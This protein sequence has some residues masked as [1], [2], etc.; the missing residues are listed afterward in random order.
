MRCQQT[1]SFHRAAA[2]EMFICLLLRHMPGPDPASGPGISGA[3]L[4]RMVLL[5]S[6]FDKGRTPVRETIDAKSCEL[7]ALLSDGVAEEPKSSSMRV[8]STKRSSSSP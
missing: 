6:A 1:P 8:T 3:S 7:R 4:N 5:S 2:T